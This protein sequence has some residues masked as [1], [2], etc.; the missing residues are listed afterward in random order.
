VSH[1][2]GAIVLRTIQKVRGCDG[3]PHFLLSRREGPW[4]PHD[5]H[6]HVRLLRA[7]VWT[8]S[9]D[10]ILEHRSGYV[11]VH[12]G[13]RPQASTGA[14]SADHNAIFAEEILDER[15]VDI[16]MLGLR[17]LPQLMVDALD[18][19]MGQY[20][21]KPSDLPVRQPIRTLS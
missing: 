15:R 16:P 5:T 1:A 9:A 18:P 14:G 4:A 6:D 7:S 8:V 20:V 2:Y 12:G 13:A 10:Q 17:T 19:T 21:A 11:D 3:R